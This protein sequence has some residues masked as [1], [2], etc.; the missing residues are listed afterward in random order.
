MHAYELNG[1][2]ILEFSVDDAEVSTA[3]DS[4]ALVSLVIERLARGI[5][6]VRLKLP[7]TRL[8]RQSA[9]GTVWRLADHFREDLS[10]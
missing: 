8:Y 4:S 2:H 9:E 1:T 6:N 10:V 5:S 7:R 3:S